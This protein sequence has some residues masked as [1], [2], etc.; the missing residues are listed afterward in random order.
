MYVW[1]LFVISGTG[2]RLVWTVCVVPTPF[3][4]PLARTG[5]HF[6]VSA[7]AFVPSHPLSATPAIKHPK[8]NLLCRQQQHIKRTGLLP[9]TTTYLLS[10]ALLLL[11]TLQPRQGDSGGQGQGDRIGTFL[12]LWFP[13][14]LS[15]CVSPETH[16]P[17]PCC[18][19]FPTM[20]AVLGLPCLYL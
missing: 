13:P 12:C 19:A 11:L 20:P 2:R 14:L 18:C 17:C 16:L 9:P 6:L 10:T 8:S 4:S 5:Q 1:M 7:R 15:T 3:N